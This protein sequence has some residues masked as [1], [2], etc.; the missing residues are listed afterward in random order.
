MHIQQRICVH[1]ACI[2]ADRRVRGFW[3]LRMQSSPTR[4]KRASSVKWQSGMKGLDG[5]C[6]DEKEWWCKAEGGDC[7]WKDGRVLRKGSLGR[8]E[9]RKGM[10]WW[11]GRKLKGGVTTPC[12]MQNRGSIIVIERRHYRG[13]QNVVVIRI[14]P[15][16]FT[17]LCCLVSFSSLPP[18]PSS[19]S[20]SLSFSFF[21]D[22]LKSLWDVDRL[23][24]VPRERPSVPF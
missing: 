13:A 4:Q 22:T 3:A 5:Y 16:V 23:R 15:F 1:I 9:R 20:L 11:R 17:S 24:D 8:W 2:Y 19:L 18:S 7:R 14:F 12:R 21:N 6:G 10:R